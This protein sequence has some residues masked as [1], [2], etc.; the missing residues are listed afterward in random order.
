MIHYDEKRRI[1]H[2]SA[3]G[4][5]YVIGIAEGQLQGLYFGKA[6]AAADPTN[7]IR[8]G[9][10]SS[11][12]MDVRVERAEYPCFD[13]HSFCE[14]C[15]KIETDRARHA[16]FTYHG[17]TVTQEPFGEKLSITLK[18]EQSRAE[19]EL[20]YKLYEAYGLLERSAV[21]HAKAELELHS[22]LSACVNLPAD[23]SYH[24]RYLT[25]RWGGEFQINDCAVGTGV[26]AIQ[27]KRGT[28]S[29]HFN[30]CIAL[31]TPEATEENG[32][33]WFGALG[34]SGNWAIK[35]EQTIFGNTHILAGIN[36]SD[37]R[38]KM[39][40][41]DMLQLP[42]FYIGFTDGGFGE[43]SRCMHR[44]ENACILPKRPLRRVLYNSWEATAFHVV[45][46]KQMRLADKAA[47]MGCE[48]FVLDD[49]WFGKRD[50][51]RAG[52]GDWTVHTGKF[53]H[54]LSEL[55]DHVNRCGMDFGIWLEPE[56][57]NPD[58]D[59]YRAHPDWIYRYADHEPLQARNQ[60][61]LNI[62]LPEVQTYLLDSI[63]TLL[64]AHHITYIKWDMNR[65]I[66]DMDGRGEETPQSLWHKHVQALYRIWAYIR[67]E[68]PN[69]E[70]ET[71]S[72]GGG[73]I[74]LGIFR[75][76]DQCWT[77]DN[78]DP[79]DRLFIQE[80]YTQFYPPSAMMCWVTDT[81]RSEHGDKEQWGHRDL[82]YR[83]HSAMCGGLGIGSDI[84]LF[85][86]EELDMCR[87]LITQYKEIRETVQEGDLY[88]LLSPRGSCTAAVE[89]VSQNKNEAVTFVFQQS[90]PLFQPQHRLL[91]LQGLDPA[92]HYRLMDEHTVHSGN[93]LME[94]G[95]P[96]DLHGEM[97]SRMIHLVKV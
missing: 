17:Y 75:Y 38:W 69:V 3:A 19:I 9:E 41:G 90:Q 71:C 56:A 15:L 47:A 14:P 45:V 24:M 96:I 95:L 32:S 94:I 68:F 59:L 26:F 60:Y 73:R 79:Y 77:S 35:V 89:Y 97:K 91:R 29:A 81:H 61:V 10:H 1:F 37:F 21:I 8:T 66:T 13:G 46:E 74:D 30:P 70:L 78:T 40:A 12:D 33:V 49:G 42:P 5:S 28:T 6:I 31:C 18:D 76:A 34:Y 88:R 86:Q 39:Q 67:S 54:G 80:G 23:R 36:D 44:F 50:N 85:H 82:T 27:S 72:G 65:A 52:L 62:T 83:F 51:D 57:V 4:M 64:K 22:A 87:T 11:F 92:A 2:L 84:D 25:G 63:T 48:L 93:D 53:P 7:M 43:M 58:S 20:I 16:F 55:I